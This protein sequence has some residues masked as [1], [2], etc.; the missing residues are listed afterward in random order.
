[1]VYLYFSS[2]PLTIYTNNSGE[3]TYHYQSIYPMFR[4]L[5]SKTNDTVSGRYWSHLQFLDITSAQCV[6]DSTT[7]LTVPF[8]IVLSSDS[9]YHLGDQFVY[10]TGHDPLLSYSSQTEIFLRV[11]AGMNMFMEHAYIHAE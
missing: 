3:Q 1:M 5:A 11:Q 6:Y 10:F 7:Y 4:I 9:L 8:D 2:L